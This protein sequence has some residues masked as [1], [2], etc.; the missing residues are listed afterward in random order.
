MKFIIEDT[1]TYEGE[2]DDIINYATQ[3]NIEYEILNVEQLYN[4]NSN[5]FLNNIYFCNTDIVQYHLSKIGKINLVPNTYDNRFNKFYNRNIEIMTVK[6][7][8]DKFRGINK[9]I[10]PYDN[11]KDFDGRVV[12]NI[13]DFELYGVKIPELN[14]KIYC[15]DPIV[16][17]SEVRLL[18]GNNKLYGHGHI[19]KNKID[20]YLNDTEFIDGIISL[21]NGK[22]LCIDIGYTFN[23]KLKI[24]Q[25]IIIEINPPFS[26]DDHEIPFNNY[27]NFCID[28]C[29][30]T[31]SYI[32]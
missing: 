9:F 32:L 4:F 7:F 20:N 23:E 26:L 24:F 14:K 27:I 15:C 10:K 8:D 25:W 29:I 5:I 21:T 18:I 16:F 11:N 3:H 31:Y 17:L 2:A 30:N 19:C 12:N 28:A 6:E 1:W 13:S 22:Y